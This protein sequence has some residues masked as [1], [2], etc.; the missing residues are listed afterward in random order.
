MLFLP[1]AAQNEVVV[2]FERW[3]AEMLDAAPELLNEEQLD[4]FE[5][6]KFLGRWS[7]R[8]PRE[9]WELHFRGVARGEQWLISHILEKRPSL[10]VDLGCGLGTWCFL[11]A[12]AGV[13]ETVGIDLSRTRLEAAQAFADSRF[14]EYSDAKIRFLYKNLFRVKFDSP[15]D[16][17]YLKASLHHILPIPDLLDY[18]YQNLAPGGIVVVHDENALHPLGQYQ[19][20][21]MRGFNFRSTTEDPETGEEMPYAR[22]DFFTIPGIIHRF[23]KHGFRTR[24]V[25]ASSGFR[26]KASDRMWWDF[27]EPLNRHWLLNSFTALGYQLVVQKPLE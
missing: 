2:T 9:R 18:L 22:E 7:R 14:S 3:L 27:M 16:I 10:F 23:K 4:S 25:Q 8:L 20:Y 11:A 1:D 21:K 6:Y 5:R 17:F 26:T 24:Y 15:V 19:A 13:Q 12:I